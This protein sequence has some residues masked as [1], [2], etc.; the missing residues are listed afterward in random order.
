[1]GWQAKKVKMIME[2]EKKFNKIPVL[3]RVC[4]AFRSLVA[5]GQI[6]KVIF[7]R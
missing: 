6:C 2:E 5:V 7:G 1:M 3:E 4:N